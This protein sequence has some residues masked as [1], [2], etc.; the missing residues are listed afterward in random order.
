MQQ[1]AD[2]KGDLLLLRGAA[3]DGG[4]FDLL[5]H[6]LLDRQAVL[7]GGDESPATGGA[8]HDGGFKALHK[9]GANGGHMLAEGDKAAAGNRVGLVLRLADQLAKFAG[10]LAIRGHLHHLHE[11]G[12]TRIAHE[13]PIPGDALHHVSRH[14]GHQNHG[15]NPHAKRAAVDGTESHVRSKAPWPSRN[16]NHSPDFAPGER[17]KKR[18]P[19]SGMPL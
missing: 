2:H 8:E 14:A 4:L 6:I 17:E 13:H 3:A 7:G 19:V 5:V 9:D 1:R 12:L 11:R 16:G 15:K 10:M 18:H